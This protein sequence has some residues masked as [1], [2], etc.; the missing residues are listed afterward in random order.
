MSVLISLVQPTSNQAEVEQNGM[1]L[2]LTPE[3]SGSV[4]EVLPIPYI[5]DRCQVCDHK[6]CSWTLPERISNT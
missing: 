6:T 5:A 1:L 3:S 2:L 4:G